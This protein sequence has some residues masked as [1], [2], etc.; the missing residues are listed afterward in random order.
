M[1]IQSIGTIAF[2]SLAWVLAAPAFGQAA[3][4]QPSEWIAALRNGGYVMVLRHGATNPDQADTDPLNIADTSKQRQLS[5]QGRALAKSMGDSLHKLNIPV[6]Q[7]QTSK[8][9]RAIETGRLLGFG[10]VSQS[11]DYTE[12]GLVVSPKENERRAQALRAAA[13][14]VPP[15]GTNVVIVTH[16]PNILD[17]FGKDWFDVREGEMSIFKPEGSGR[18]TLVARVPAADWAKLAQTIN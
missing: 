13:G 10:D 12:G 3:P 15:A 16:K 1:L 2:A 11:F 4:T 14:T 7:V 8:F 9:Y 17:A 5:D 18:Y 6:G